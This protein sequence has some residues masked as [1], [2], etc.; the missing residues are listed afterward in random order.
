[1]GPMKPGNRRKSAMV[2]IPA[3]L[4]CKIREGSQFIN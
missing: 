4:V 2:P 3:D 1:M